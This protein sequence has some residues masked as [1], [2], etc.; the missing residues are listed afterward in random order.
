[1]TDDKIHFDV[2]EPPMDHACGEDLTLRGGIG[3]EAGKGAT[4][5]FGGSIIFNLPDDS[6]KMRIK[7]D[8]TVLIDG[9]EVTTDLAMYKAL[10]SWLSSM[11][12]DYEPPGCDL[13]PLASRNK[14]GLEAAPTPPEPDTDDSGG[15]PA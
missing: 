10:A 6:E 1:M 14:E 8:G 5:K 15:T 9:R 12:V 13:S 2:A 7:P 3:Y 11:V 4:P